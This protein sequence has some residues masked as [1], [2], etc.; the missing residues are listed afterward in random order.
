MPYPYAI[1]NP[2]I[3][4][5]AHQRAQAIGFPLMPKGRPVGKPA[6]ATATTPADGALLRWLATLHSPGSIAE[7][8]TG[9]GVSTAWLISGMREDTTLVSC[10]LDEVLVKGAIEFFS[11]YPNLTFRFGDWVN[12]LA[13][14]APYDLVFFDANA[15]DVLL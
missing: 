2:D 9:P 1:D 8:G 11:G 12:A 7:I 4:H 5:R 10:D 3:V 14:D 13:G 15:R 6:P